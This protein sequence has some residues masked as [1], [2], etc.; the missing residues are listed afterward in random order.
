MDVAIRLAIYLP[1]HQPGRFSFVF[2]VCVQQRRQATTMITN[3]RVERVVGGELATLIPF[4]HD[5][6]VPEMGYAL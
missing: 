3:Y 5:N 2:G 1:A 4:C 6:I